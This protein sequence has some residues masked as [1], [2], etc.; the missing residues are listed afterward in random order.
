[1]TLLTKVPSATMAMLAVFLAHGVFAQAKWEAPTSAASTNN[2]FVGNAVAL[3]EGTRIY[4]KYCTPCHGE[5]GNGEGPV[6][7][8]LNPKPANHSSATV[9]SQ[10]DGVLFWKISEG[11]GAMAAYKNQLT[12]QQ[13]WGLVNYI[14]TLKK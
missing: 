5:K 14:R 11:R 8:T 12:D 10:P 6:A 13:R 9:Q 2:P 1:M 7:A 4:T 3:K